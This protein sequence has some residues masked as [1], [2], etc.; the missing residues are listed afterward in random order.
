[1]AKK[2]KIELNPT[3][4][5]ACRFKIVKQINKK[6]SRSIL[7]ERKIPVGKEVTFLGVVFETNTSFNKQVEKGD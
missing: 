2:N 7:K 1:M 3:K 4:S 6:S 5:E